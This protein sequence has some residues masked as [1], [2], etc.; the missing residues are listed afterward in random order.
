MICRLISRETV[1]TQQVSREGGVG[2][3]AITQS[4]LFV[5]DM[6]LMGTKK[7]LYVIL[8]VLKYC[9]Q[10]K[11]KDSTM[12]KVS[13]YTL[14][15]AIDSIYKNVVPKRSK[16]GAALRAI[17]RHVTL[18]SRFDS[19]SEDLEAEGITRVEVGE[20]GLIFHR[21]GTQG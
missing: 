10:R 1:V 17:L 2:H 11:S 4:L 5:S 13:S 20:E 18:R 7:E 16:F 21:G 9:T 15:I 19:V 14:K 12:S 8:K 3:H 6:T